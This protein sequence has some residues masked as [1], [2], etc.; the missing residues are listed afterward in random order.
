MSVSHSNEMLYRQTKTDLFSD[1]SKDKVEQREEKLS[2]KEESTS[3]VTKSREQIERETKAQAVIGSYSERFAKDWDSDLNLTMSE[4]AYSTVKMSDIRKLTKGKNSSGSAIELRN[5][6]LEMQA[7]AMNKDKEVSPEDNVNLLFRLSMASHNYCNSHQGRRYTFEGAAKQKLAQ[8]MRNQTTG[9]LERLLSKDEIKAIRSDH[10]AVLR[11]GEDLK[12]VT[13]DLQRAAKAYEKF[14]AQLGDNCQGYSAEE[15][16]QRKLD[17]LR[18]NERKIKLYRMA[19]PDLVKRDHGI[20]QMIREYEESV[21]WEKVL[22]STKASKQSMNIDKL[23]EEHVEKEGE[24]AHKGRL[25]FE[26]RNEGLSEEQLKGLEDIDNWLIRNCQ[27]GGVLGAFTSGANVS[28]HEFAA[29]VL[30]LSKRERLHMYYL[31]E[32]KRRKVATEDDVDDSQSSTYAPNLDAFKGQILSTKWNFFRRINGGYTHMGKLSDAF[33]KTMEVREKIKAFGDDPKYAE[34]LAKDKIR[35]TEETAE[36]KKDKFSHEENAKGALLGLRIAGETLGAEVP[37]YLAEGTKELASKGIS[38]G[39][40]ALSLG[41]AIT[42]SV[43][44]GKMR[45]YGKD[46]RDYF[47]K[48]RRFLAESNGELSKEDKRTAKYE[49]CME[50]L[51][52]DLQSRQAK[53]TA[54]SWVKTGMYVGALAI[55]I[56]GIAVMG[57]E[58]IVEKKIDSNQVHALRNR[59][60]DGFYN[61]DSLVKKVMEN[62]KARRTMDVPDAPEMS[63]ESLRKSLRRRLATQMGFSSENKAALSICRNF[64]KTIRAK[65]F[66]K[67]SEGEKE[68]EA[69]KKFVLSLNLPFDEQK[70]QPTENVLAQRM[71]GA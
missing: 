55:P 20:Q 31:V 38:A 45:Y 34:E 39:V 52:Q 29:R 50:R 49:K 66:E 56:L 23:I 27:N 25:S 47:Q 53:D 41:L 46:A 70:Q 18:V 13:S 61:I 7:L 6:M 36:K 4:F 54:F 16:L 5:C 37:K 26:D 12:S 11:K 24:L 67:K 33:Q 69:Y 22:A 28:K 1:I 32:K 8:R 51:Q 71:F 64:A 57:V 59:L 2:Y 42:D 3:S 17:A 40:A 19:Y 65:L 44:L 30:S 48:K 63:E 60:V 21:A 68:Y 58:M 15:I 35:E 10:G 62:K 9:C 14:S 43:K